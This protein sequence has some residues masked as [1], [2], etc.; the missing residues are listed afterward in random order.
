MRRVT[1]ITFAAMPALVAPHTQH[2]Q[3]GARPRA[4]IPLKAIEQ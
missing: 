4:A 2:P 1:T 3:Y